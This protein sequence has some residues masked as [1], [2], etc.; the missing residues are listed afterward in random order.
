MNR[1][2]ISRLIKRYIYIYG[3]IEV[4][5]NGLDVNWLLFFLFEKQKQDAEKTINKKR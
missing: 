4:G 5:K 2:K 3:M 1:V